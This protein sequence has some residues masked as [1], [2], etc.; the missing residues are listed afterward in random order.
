MFDS[1]GVKGLLRKPWT[2]ALTVIAALAIVCA[3]VM[4]P[5]GK[6][7][8]DKAQAS[9][10][11]KNFTI[12][13]T[14]DEHSEIYPYDLA[15]DYPGNP[16][17]GGF[18]RLAKT[19]TDIK[20]ARA[21]AGEPV[22]T[23]G[24]GDWSQG[25]LFSWLETGA[26][27]ELTLMQMMGYD[28]VTI[29]NHDVELGPQ[30]LAAELNAAATGAGGVAVNLPILSSNITFSGGAKDAALYNFWSP[31]DVQ[32]ASLKIQPYTTKTLSNGLKVGMFGLLGVDAEVDAPGEAPLSFGNVPGDPTSPTS[33]AHRVTVAQSMVDTLRNTEHCDVVVCLS[34]EGTQEEERLADSVPSIDVIIGGHSHDLNYPPIVRPGGTIIVQAKANSEYLGDLEL[35]YDPYPAAGRKVAVRNAQAIH[36]DQTVETVPAIDGLVNIYLAVLNSHLVPPSFPA[37]FNCLN[38]FAETDLHGDGGFPLPNEPA[39]SETQIGDLITDAYRAETSTQIGI[40]ANGVI[41]TGLAKGATGVF[42][43]YDLYRPIP[44]GLSPYDSPTT[45]GYPLCAFYLAGAEIRGVLNQLLDMNSN[46]YF[47]QVSGLKYTYDPNG[48]AGN[49]VVSLTVDSGG[50][51]YVPINP[52]GLYKLAA[53]YYVG[54]FMVSE[55]LFPRDVTGA[56]H[57]P[58]AYPDPMKDFRVLTGATT[59][60]KAWQALTTAVSNFPDLDGDGLPNIPSTYATTQ[61]RIIRLLVPTTTTLSPTSKIAGQPAFT[62][63]VNGTNFVNNSVVTWNGTPLSTSYVDATHLT[64]T[65]PAADLKTAGAFPVTVFNPGPGGGTSAPQPFTVNAAPV[66]ASTFYFAEGTTRTNFQEY[67]CLGNSGDQAASAKV[68]YLFTDGTTKDA[69][70]TVPANSRYTVDVNSVVG[71]NKDLSLEVQSETPNLVAERPMYFNYNGTWTGGHDAVGAV[72]PNTKWYFAEGNTLPEFDQ[73]VTVLNPGNAA[74]NL[75]FHYMVEGQGEKLVTGQV[76]PHSR[77]TFKTRDQIGDGKHVS[78]YLESTQGVVAERPMYFNYLGLAQN[79]WTGGH[80]VVGTNSPA[81]D[82]YFAEGTTRKNSVDGAFEQWL[83]LQNPG[84]TSLTVTATYQLAAGQGNP[85]SKSYTVPAQQRRTVSVNGEIGQDKDCSV[86]LHSTSNFIAERPMYFSYHASAW[87]GG[88]DVLGVNSTATTWFFGEGTTRT[89]FEE[90]LCLQNPGNSDAHTTIRYYTTSGQV[91]TKQWT[92]KANTRL[93]VSA[94]SDVGADQDISTRVSSD[95]PIIVE[96]PMYFDY[97]GWTG[98]HDVVGFVPSP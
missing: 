95:K 42:S 67:L 64:A 25:T 3:L 16:T 60:L 79:N 45:P 62:L 21:A 90:W 71:P 83:C 26:A 69:S 55:G 98:G 13:H 32:R 41:R 8:T 77:K 36:M 6:G 44:L 93:T 14:N 37:G 92:V 78:L 39:M 49:K 19:I 74:A 81:K 91:I 73:Y 7:V 84:T 76:G 80:D 63:T 75:K 24:A 29:G 22:L 30:Y 72:A 23:L 68:T 51:V 9:G 2:R 12:L 27:P 89:N 86:Y 59:E 48:A 82:W 35:Q 52:A 54:W 1:Q 11:V 88:H 40:E 31:T 20:T 97:N 87:T 70:Y 15:R 94:N 5:V 96:R 4:V 47:V 50:G 53:N 33:Y 34:H 43:F 61:G 18:S 58:P 28:A 66:N 65:V 46:T 85:I 56:Q 57:K 10:G 38:P 17:T